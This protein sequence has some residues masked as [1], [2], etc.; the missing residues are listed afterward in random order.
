MII[1]RHLTSPVEGEGLGEKDSV[2][3]EGK[4]WTDLH[5]EIARKA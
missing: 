2:E 4:W 1:H 3:G 5:Q